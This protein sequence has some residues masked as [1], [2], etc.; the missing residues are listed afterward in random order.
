MPKT[1]VFTGGHHNSALVVAK[2]LKTLG[3][4][5]VW[6]GHKFTMRG[7]KQ[8]AAE[9]QEVTQSGFP[10]YELKTGKFYRV[11]DPFELLK[12]PLGFFQ[13]FLYLSHARPDLPAPAWSSQGPRQEHRRQESSMFFSYSCDYR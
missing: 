12:I 8:V 5:I 1:I 2:R 10:F 3:H 4:Q 6:I 13:A 11:H 9:Y 7:D